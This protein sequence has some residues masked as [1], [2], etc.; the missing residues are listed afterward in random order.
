MKIPTK[1]LKVAGGLILSLVFLLF[2]ASVIMQDKAA[3]II[4]KS[5]NKNFSTKIETGS[6]HLS[7][8]KK[9][10]K[11]SFE[12]KNVLVH[13]SPDFDSYAFRGISTDTLLTAKYASIDFKIIDV[14]RGV[15]TFK[16]INVRSGVLNLYT[17]TSG[18]SNYI[19]SRTGKSKE[20]E[21]TVVLNLERI[22]LSDVR[23]LYN[24]LRVNLIIRGIFEEGR[25]KSRIE[26]SKIDFDGNSMVLFDTFILGKTSYKQPVKAEMRVAL[27]KNEKG[28]FFRKST[29]SIEKQDL[30]LTGYVAAD[31]YLDLDISSDG[32]DIS[33]VPGYLPPKFKNI[34]AEYDPSGNFKFDCRI[35]GKATRMISP[36]FDISGSM[37]D[38][39]IFHNRS[40]MKISRLSFEGNFTNGSLNKSATSTISIKNF[41][42][43]LGSSVYKGSFSLTDFNRPDAALAFNGTV[44]PSDI[45]EFLNLKNVQSTEGSVELDIRMSGLLKKKDHYSLAD[46]SEM[47]SDS[48]IG[49]KSCGIELKNKNIDLRDLNGQIH[50]DERALSNDISFIL[51][52]QKFDLS[53]NFADLPQWLAGL[54]VTLNGSVTVSAP[55][56]KPELFMKESSGTEVKSVTTAPL[57]LPEDLAVDVNLNLDTLVYKTFDA[58]NIRGQLSFKPHMVNFKSVKFSSQGGEVTGNGLIV[59][60]P[61][62]SFVGRGSF[63]VSNVDVNRSFK[64]FNNFGQGFIKAENLAGTLSGTIT[65]V[66]PADSMLHPV[67]KSL[68]AEG[69]YRIMN[70]AL[71]NFDPV[72]ALSTFIE[73]SELE[74][75][76]FDQLDNDFFIRNNYFYLPQMDIR[77]SAADLSVNG[78]HSFENE[79]QY[80][81]R[82]HL[83]EL[84]SN[85]ARKRKDLNSE[86]GEVKD[87]GLGRTL[88][89]LRIDGKGSNA[90]VSYDMKAAKNK[91]KDDFRKERENLKNILN[92]EYGTNSS[93]PE[94]ANDKQAKPRFRISWEGSETA[95]KETESPSGKKESVL[96]KIFRKK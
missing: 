33:R 44:K 18:H 5:L 70:G 42:A 4:L 24:D 40:G 6:Y 64:S 8:L 9:F 85:K 93:A 51:N 72:K 26:G 69:R 41:N 55:S 68:T 86:F 61:D 73:L 88:V 35:K 62:K 94:S 58:R 19:V 95:D 83:S 45:K 66:L 28:F 3:D 17:D 90:D 15:Y 84:L 22:N 78:L 71:I 75:I 23:F 14:F 54:P 60:N 65:M 27:V 32:V 76:R 16:K 67:M 11:A 7:F 89:F 38:G 21:N 47:R 30:I 82:I 87:D 31:N 79:Y 46:L 2:F 36:H 20:G 13:S 1:L 37:K 50:I 29:M 80:H 53:C 77:S 43:K 39:G 91:I 49:F 52:K 10:P 48:E 57:S 74:N 63:T 56:L 12:L 96:K 59:Q 34:L 92:E 81:V 25:I